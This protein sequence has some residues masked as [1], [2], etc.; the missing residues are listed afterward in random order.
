MSDQPILEMLTERLDLDDW[1][2]HHRA[3]EILREIRAAGYEIVQRRPIDEQHTI[4]FNWNYWIISH[5]L[6]ERIS[7][8]LYDCEWR[9]EGE[10]PRELGSYVLIDNTTLGR[11]L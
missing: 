4:H 9:W 5:P 10:D 1:D 8:H 3:E 2:D 6:H 7:G 11:R